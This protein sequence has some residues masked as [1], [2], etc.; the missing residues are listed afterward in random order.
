MKIIGID[1]AGKDKNPTGFCI[2]TDGKTEVKLLNTNEEILKE[3]NKIEP[4]V[5]SPF[6]QGFQEC[7]PW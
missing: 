2:L 1:L 3:V 5:V 6:L 7:N 4:D